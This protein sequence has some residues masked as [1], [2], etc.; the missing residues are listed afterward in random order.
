[1]KRLK[2]QG[3]PKMSVITVSDD[4]Y[5]NAETFKQLYGEEEF[6]KLES[7]DL[8]YWGSAVYITIEKLAEM[9]LITPYLDYSEE[10]EEE[11]DVDEKDLGV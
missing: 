1:M 2:Q 5:M 3:K 10:E 8:Y 9:G 4:A 6:N 11:L 7:F